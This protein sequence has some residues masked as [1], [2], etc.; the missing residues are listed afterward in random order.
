MAPPFRIGSAAKV[1]PQ[2]YWQTRPKYGGPRGRLQ[3]GRWGVVY[4]IVRRRRDDA[5]KREPVAQGAKRRV[6]NWKD[7]REFCVAMIAML[8]AIAIALPKLKPRYWPAV[9]GRL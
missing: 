9:R 2:Q 6:W 4:L 8:A 1:S 7:I 3:I 5:L